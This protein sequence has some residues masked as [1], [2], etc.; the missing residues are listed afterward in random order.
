MTD[1]KCS[2]SASWTNSIL[3]GILMLV[4]GIMKLF[5]I[6]PSAVTGM[7]SSFGFPIAGFFAWIL[8]LA[9]IITGIAILARWNL[10]YTTIPPAIIIVFAG[11]LTSLSLQTLPLFLMHLVIASNYI[12]LGNCCK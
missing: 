1:C 5:V 8:I 7:L 3:L 9:E 12:Y 6:G 2:T 11:L 10:K 4:P